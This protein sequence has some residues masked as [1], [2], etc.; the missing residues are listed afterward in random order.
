MIEVLK[1]TLEQAHTQN[2]TF[3]DSSPCYDP[4][5]STM[6]QQGKHMTQYYAPASVYIRVEKPDNTLMYQLNVNVVITVDDEM[7]EACAAYSAITG[8]G[9]AIMGAVNGYMGI[10]YAL[11]SLGCLFF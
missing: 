11:A 1:S 8:M 2:S 10:P 6:P 7:E 4:S 3:Y 5:C 9:G